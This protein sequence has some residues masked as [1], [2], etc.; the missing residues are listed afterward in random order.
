MEKRT[1]LAIVVSILS[2]FLILL[3]YTKFIG[4]IP[5][6]VNNVNTNKTDLFRV[7]GN[8]EAAAIPDMAKI[9]IGVT[10]S[11]KN[12]TDAQT[13]VNSKIKN[14]TD[15]LIGLGVEEKN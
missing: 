10:E 2:F 11:S 13:K 4:P 6:A 12:V 8:G 9:L 1:V 7:T 15:A 5:F 3:V 14:I